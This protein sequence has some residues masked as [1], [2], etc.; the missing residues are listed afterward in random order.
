MILA[1]GCITEQEISLPAERI[2]LTEGFKVFVGISVVAC[3]GR[4]RLELIQSLKLSP[5]V[6]FYADIRGD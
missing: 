2:S 1:L 3:G 4:R 5:N 6:E